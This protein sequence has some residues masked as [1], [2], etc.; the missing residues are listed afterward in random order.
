MS[1]WFFEEQKHSLVL[2]EYLRRFRPEL[3]PT[4]Q[5]LHEVRFEFEP[6]PALE[7]PDAALLRRDPAQ[8]LVPPSGSNG[9]PSR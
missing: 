5:E 4:E 7:T 8:P 9:T 6:A 1:I 2:I 3:A